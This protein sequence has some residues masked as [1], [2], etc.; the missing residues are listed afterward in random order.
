MSTAS[1]PIDTR[2]LPGLGEPTPVV[3]LPSDA[4]ASFR[5][6]ARYLPLK[7][8]DHLGTHASAGEVLI[9]CVTGKVDAVV[10]EHEHC[11]QPN[12]I[13]HVSAGSPFRLEAKED[14]AVLITSLTAEP[15]R[16]RESPSISEPKERQFDEVQEALEESFPASDPPSYNASHS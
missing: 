1:N 4:N 6:D 14:S 9:F 12:Q 8:N 2:D 16:H 3:A 5:A 15:T 11:L 10:N 13:I 7:A